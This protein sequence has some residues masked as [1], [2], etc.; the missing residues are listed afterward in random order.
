L[1]FIFFH[2]RCAQQYRAWEK[3]N[4]QYTG[5]RQFI[6]GISGHPDL[7]K[8][9]EAAL[10]GM[11]D[12]R[13]KPIS[14]KTITELQASDMAV[15]LT[16]RLDQ[17]E[18][19]APRQNFPDRQV[20]PDTTMEFGMG[21]EIMIPQPSFGDAQQQQHLSTPFALI[22]TDK[23]THANSLPSELE[24]MGW[25]VATVYGA[26]DCLRLLQMRQWDVVLVDDDLSSGSGSTC[27]KAFRSWEGSNRTS[28]QKNVFLVCGGDI[29]S[30][31]DKTSVI[32][33]PD[34][35]DGILGRPVKLTELQFLLQ[36]SGNG[37]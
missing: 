24:S 29:P 7:N 21:N 25:K 32:Q 26:H 34:G 37:K 17:I 9:N 12:F 20:P 36:R 6:V 30:L 18:G 31:M 35:F 22:A 4:H 28:G 15:Q 3:H 33:P 8:N 27:V 19:S 5:T 16:R 23:P 2:F 11:D 10:A 14:L 1:I 13:P